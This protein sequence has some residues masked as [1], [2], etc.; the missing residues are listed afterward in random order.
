MDD[1][2]RRCGFIAEVKPIMKEAV[3]T[4][5]QMLLIDG[6]LKKTPCP[7]TS[8]WWDRCKECGYYYH[9]PFDDNRCPCL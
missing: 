3:L 7:G 5:V 4:R 1:F 8:M 9:N 2:K 6:K